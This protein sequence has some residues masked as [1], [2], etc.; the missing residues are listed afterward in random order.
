M[1]SK[2]A[3][4]IAHGICVGDKFDEEATSRYT[5][6]MAQALKLKLADLAGQIGSQEQKL[7]WADSQVAISAVNWTPVL[8]E[9]R[10]KLYD[11]LGVEQL[12][13]FF[14][15]REF[16]FQAIADSLTYQVTHSQLDD[17]WGYKSIHRCFADTLRDLAQEE[18]A[19][20]KAPLCII[21]HSL[22]TVITSNYIYDLETDKAQIEIG[23]T[24]LERGETLTS[25]YT[26]ASQIPFWSL[27][28]PNFDRPIKVPAEK[29]NQYYSGLPGEWINFYNESD[30]L[31]YPLK[32]LNDAYSKAVTGDKVVNAGDL[33]ASWNPL[34]HNKY[35][36][37]EN[38][39]N[40]IATGLHNI[41]K[42]LEETQAHPS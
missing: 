26:L 27:R 5:G 3:V 23:D 13:S 40:T 30:I 15:L 41:L 22:G 2:I 24:P 38:V 17:L 33:L 11:R 42:Q 12:N 35:W 36:T 20:S 19:G 16:M 34:S 32:T 18:Q 21:A 31:G 9:E 37:D 29:L 8:R 14:G 1:S 25:V 7:K 10:K 6:G 28:Y 4:A 39:I